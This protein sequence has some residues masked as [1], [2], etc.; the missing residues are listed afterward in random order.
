MVARVLISLFL[1]I[2]GAM[3]DGNE[4]VLAAV[5]TMPEGGGY[6]TSLTA[7]Q[8]LASSVETGNPAKIFPQRAQPSYCSGATYLVFLKA[9]AALEAQGALSLDRAT[10]EALKPRLRE[11]GKDTLPDG[12]G[13]WGRWNANGPGTA[14]LFYELGLGENF[15]S[16]S[17]ARPGDFMKI[18]WTDAVG[19]KESGH[20][21]IYL[22]SLRKDGID[23]VRI[24]SSNEPEGTGEKIIPR[25]KIKHAIFSRLESPSKIAG[26][27]ALPASDAYLASL[28]REESSFSEAEK[29]SGIR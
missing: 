27:R 10:W 13:I 23:C 3:A 9:L 16:F 1:T 12:E 29:M 26:W 15:T 5:R 6:G 19:R 28:G 20:S 11:D 24:W 22:G 25:E 17:A 21:V 7:H 2:G 14:R 8:A 4:A 18:F